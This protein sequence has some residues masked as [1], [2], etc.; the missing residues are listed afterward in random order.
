[1]EKKKQNQPKHHAAKNKL[2]VKARRKKIIK[3][4]LEGKTQ[5]EIAE[6]TDLSPKTGRQQV[7]A[8]LS[9]PD[10]KECFKAILDKAVPDD[11][12]ADKYVQ[13]LESQKVISAN[14]IAQSGEGMA[15]AHAMTKDFIEVPDCM[16]QLN[17]AN[18]IAKLKGYMVEKRDNKH[19]FDG[20]I[21][22]AVAK[23][24]SGEK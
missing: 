21:M 2:A 11:T 17:T 12:L 10:I 14:V 16:A 15:D 20:S 1:M 9:E 19:T 24:L 5:K 3:G 13:L 18:S 7:A 6:D 22:A 8:I 4:I 23:Q